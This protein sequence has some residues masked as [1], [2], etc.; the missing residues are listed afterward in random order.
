[1]FIVNFVSTEKSQKK[2]RL[3]FCPK[4]SSFVKKRRNMTE[5][6]KR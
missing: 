2:H 4:T 6:N 3:H 1:M 5:I